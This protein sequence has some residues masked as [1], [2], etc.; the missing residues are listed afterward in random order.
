MF[1]RRHFLYAG[2]GVGVTA[3]LSSAIT[4]VAGPLQGALIAGAGRASVRLT[5]LYPLDDFVGEHDPL[6]VRV[7]LME[8]AGQRQ[9][10]V[11][12]DMT[13]L[14]EQVIARMKTL[15]S[16]VAGV[17]ADNIIVNA[18]HSFSTPHIMKDTPATKAAF[19]AFETALREA[20]A[21]A[22][23]SLQPA[24][25]GA[26]SG[27]G[28]VGVNRNIETPFGWWLGADDAGYS[29]PHIGVI[30]LAREDGKAA[31]RFSQLLRATRSNGCFRKGGGWP[32]GECRSGRCCLPLY[33]K[34]L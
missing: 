31:G 1:T 18:S 13:S 6:Y 5:G 25:L 15:L 17:G 16:G 3:M 2:L 28:R 26:G 11:Q 14:S 19:A 22:M 23:S 9:A 27:F 10:I 34:S 8:F 7:L 4:A 32:P 30:G 33:R 21:Q 12:V 20:V 24:R 29:D